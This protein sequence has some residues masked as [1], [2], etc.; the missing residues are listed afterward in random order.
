M[1]RLGNTHL[2]DGAVISGDFWMYVLEKDAVVFHRLR[3][4]GWLEVH[5]RTLALDNLTGWALLACDSNR[6]MPLASPES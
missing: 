3:S 1:S 6:A 4:E 2:H 5:M